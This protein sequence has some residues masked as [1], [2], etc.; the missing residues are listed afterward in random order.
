[1][2]SK[3]V[4]IETMEEVLSNTEKIIL[5]SKSASNVLPYLPLDRLKKSRGGGS[6]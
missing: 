6:Q 2:I 4:Y 5:D 3:R 1:V